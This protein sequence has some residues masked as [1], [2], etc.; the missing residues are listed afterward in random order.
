MLLWETLWTVFCE[1][2]LLYPRIALVHITWNGNLLSQFLTLFRLVSKN[3]IL[4]VFETWQ[5][6]FPKNVRG[7]KVIEKLLHFRISSFCSSENSHQHLSTGGR[8]KICVRG[9]CEGKAKHFHPIRF[10]ESLRI[11]CVLVWCTNRG[12][13]RCLNLQSIS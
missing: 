5:K 7:R 4:H 3:D 12:H 6:D 9:Y 11:A 2:V 13:C 1:Q 10:T 8:F